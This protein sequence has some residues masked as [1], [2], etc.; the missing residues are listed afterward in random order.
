MGISTFTDPKNYGPAITLG[1]GE[2]K[3]LEMTDAFAVFA[4]GGLYR[5][6]T[7]FLEIKD[8]HGNMLY[9]YRDSGGERALSEGVAF[10]I[11]DILS[12]D[13]AR[14]EVFG[15]G[16][17]LAIPNVAVK[18]GTTDDKRDNYAIGFTKDIVIGTWVGNNNNDPM[19]AVASG[20]SGAS[21]IW[22]RAMLEFIKTTPAVHFDAPSNVK[23][24]EVDK[25]TGMKPYEDFEKK[26]EWFIDGTEPTSVS[27]WYKRLEICKIDGRIANDSC[28]DAD[29]TETETYID[30]QDIKP[31][32]QMYADAWI[33]EEYSGKSEYFPPHMTSALEFDG[34]DVDEDADPKI[35][36]INFEDGD[37]APLTFRLKVE[38]S[39]PADVEKIEFF[40]DGEK[41]SED[42]SEPYG[43][44]FTL[45]SGQAGE[46]KFRAK[47]TNDKGNT[48]DTEITLRIGS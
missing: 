19:T 1:G 32:W 42:E 44:N 45:T 36:I 43:R 29:E 14:A 38:V 9:Q 35:E 27:D 20:V 26:S 41:V 13:G 34:D 31:E 30:I 17:L 15:T 3:L 33:G 12:D 48:D 25:L 47:V 6:P 24:M 39:S 23:K 4:S 8:P 22:R 37:S 10:L 28:K 40:M 5:P 11:S 2:T 18:T 46:H 7:P 21:P 16:S